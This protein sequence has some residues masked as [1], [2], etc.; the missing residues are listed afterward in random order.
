MNASDS[1]LCCFSESANYF[2]LERMSDV[3]G[4]KQVYLLDKPPCSIKPETS[5]NS[6]LS[7]QDTQDEPVFESGFYESKKLGK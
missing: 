5:R 1:L 3:C 2:C 6:S 4:I 7:L